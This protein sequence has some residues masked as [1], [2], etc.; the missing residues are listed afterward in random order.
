MR[1]GLYT[2]VEMAV[3]LIW[4]SFTRLDVFSGKDGRFA[5][6]GHAVSKQ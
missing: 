3:F 5:I 2:G 6:V 1:Y 4:V